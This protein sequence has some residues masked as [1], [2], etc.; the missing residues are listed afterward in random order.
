M[1]YK[2]NIESF[3]KIRMGVSDKGRRNKERRIGYII[4]Q[5]SKWRRLFTHG[6]YN[7]KDTF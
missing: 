7:D 3:N 2:N 4:E 1:H 5:V 6:G